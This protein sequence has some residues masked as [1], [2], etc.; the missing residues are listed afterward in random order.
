MLSWNT[1]IIIGYRTPN[2]K[3]LQQVQNTVNK[4][5]KLVTIVCILIG[6]QYIEEK[7]YK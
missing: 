4:I 5:Q 7:K 3:Q 6:E 1:L 2:Y